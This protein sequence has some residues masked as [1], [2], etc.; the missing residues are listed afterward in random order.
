MNGATLQWADFTRERPFRKLALPTYPFERRRY[1]V[2]PYRPGVENS[3]ARSR[4][5][6]LGQRA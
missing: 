6:V 5:E 4:A 1:W 3:L 2:E